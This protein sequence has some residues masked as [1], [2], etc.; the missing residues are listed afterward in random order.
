M[1]A[2]RNGTT[3][4]RRLLTIGALFLLFGGFFIFRL[5]SLQIF[6]HTT[7][8]ARARAQR[9][10][11]ASLAPRRGTIYF[12]DAGS[13][14]RR[15]VAATER[16][17]LLLYAVPK[18]VDQPKR[19]ARVIAPLIQMDEL[20]LVQK[21]QKPDDPYEVLARDVPENAVQKILTY[22]FRGIAIAREP[23]RT[24]PEKQLASHV[25]GF[26]GYVGD[27]R[28]GV[29]GVEGYFDSVL[30]GRGGKAEVEYDV[31]G[32]PIIFAE[33]KVEPVVNGSD[34]VLTID[35]SVER[36]VCEKVKEAA[37]RHNAE[38]VSATVVDPK[39]GAIIALCAYPDFDPNTYATVPDASV[40]HN[41]AIFM[42]YEP[43]S[44]FKPITM[45]A[46]ID[47][48]LV[49]P[50]D[51][52]VDEGFL[53]IGK[54]TIRNSDGRRHGIQTMLQVL[55]ESLNTGAVYVAEKV[56]KELFRKYV[57][58]FGFG[59]LPGIEL[60]SEVAGDLSILFKRGQIYLATASYGQGIT[61]TQL[62]LVMAYAAI[63]NGGNLMKPYIR[64]ALISPDGTVERH[65]PILVRRV[66]ESK[67]A[68]LLS[69]MLVSVV[70]EGHGKRAKVPGYYV[71]GKTGT[72]QIPKKDGPGYEV[73]SNIGSFAG[74][75]PVSDPRF[76]IAVRVD[77]PKD[78]QWAESSAAPLFG[79]IARFLVQYYNI[80]P[81]DVR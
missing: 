75:L 53:Q 34:I 18:L 58:D 79:E 64:E 5:A 19:A 21:L 63:A 40:Y 65:E 24:Y 60:K 7:L 15:A 22:S 28:R 62:Q 30:A 47:L 6:S 32:R 17:A 66:L 38:R 71:A 25:L 16:D 51:T 12:T 80:P 72:A 9:S 23:M 26:Y 46:G 39:T 68:T 70:E 59:A 49:Q 37:V 54:F 31:A 36:V 27:K 13:S 44:I 77:R 81:D 52:Y 50:T 35:R 11:I 67:T 4:N 76:A 3:H 45:A 48:G 56:G 33:E 2:P 73:G 8:I 29:Y 20:L 74:F 57:L 10:T 61:A 41:A 14:E 42:P 69:G 1:S 78:V 43:G 55:D